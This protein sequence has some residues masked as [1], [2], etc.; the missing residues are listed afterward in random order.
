M[1]TSQIISKLGD[2]VQQ[3]QISITPQQFEDDHINSMTMRYIKA[4]C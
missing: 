4:A 3:E 1:I 2:V